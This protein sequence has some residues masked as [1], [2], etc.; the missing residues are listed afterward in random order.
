MCLRTSLVSI[1]LLFISFGSQAASLKLDS[2]TSGSFSYGLTL[3]WFENA[4]FPNGTG[5]T[6]SGVS[7]VT[8][9]TL[10]FAATCFTTAIT[11]SSVTLTQTT[12]QVACSFL[13]P[14][15]LSTQ[16]TNLFSLNLLLRTRTQFSTR[17][18]GLLARA[19]A[20]AGTVAAAT[21]E[22]SAFALFGSG[23]L[24]VAGLVKRNSCEL[25]CIE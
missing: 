18:A 23:L 10:S 14:S 24:G 5:I 20:L 17:L 19:E 21:P 25:T 8:G 9:V 6:L 15:S 7:G 3:D 16:F 2:A 4:Y 11:A 12:N 1:V 13:N 22:P